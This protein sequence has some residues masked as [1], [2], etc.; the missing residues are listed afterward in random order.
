MVLALDIG[1]SEIAIGGFEN[2]ALQFISH[3]ETNGAKDGV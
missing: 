3:I 2:D 1:N